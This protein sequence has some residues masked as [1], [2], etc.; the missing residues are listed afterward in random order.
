MHQEADRFNDAAAKDDV[1]AVSALLDE[2]IPVDTKSTDQ[3]TIIS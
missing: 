3:V 2:G 1:Q